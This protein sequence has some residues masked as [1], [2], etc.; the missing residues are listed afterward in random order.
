MNKWITYLYLGLFCWGCAPVT[1][2]SLTQDTNSSNAG[3]RY[4]YITS[5]ACY[6]GGV[7]T[8]AGSFTIARY[9]K[10]SG[11]FDR[12]IL[13][14]GEVAVNDAPVSLIQLSIEQLLVLV[15]NT[16]GRRFDLLDINRGQVTSYLINSTALNGALRKFTK[17]TDGSFLVAKSTAIEKFNSAKARVTQGAN[18]FV[19]NPQGS[20]AGS[21]TLISST[22]VLT[23]GKILFTHAATSPNNRIGVISATGYAAPADCLATQTAPTT[24]ALPTSILRHSSGKILVAYGSTTASSNLIYSYDIDATSG[25]ISNAIEAYNDFA[26]I[27]G[28]SAMVEDVNTGDVFIANANSSFNTVEKFYF[29][30]TSGILTKATNTAFIPPSIFTRCISGMSIGD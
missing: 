19:N 6:S 30:P 21:A 7:T 2:K 27:N 5:G 15:E 20:C 23:N 8:S 28:P 18:P 26:I 17:L 13:D 1:S 9:S 16:G 22:D 3:G 11:A 29:N 4:L 25:T 10:T 12:L 14:Y 24:T